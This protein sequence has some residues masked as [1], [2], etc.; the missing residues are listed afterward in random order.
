M[1]WTSP[2]SQ[3]S[4]DCFPLL[5]LPLVAFQ[6]LAG[7]S[8]PFSECEFH[9]ER[10]VSAVEIPLQVHE[11]EQSSLI[12][13]TLMPKARAEEVRRSREHPSPKAA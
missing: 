13:F 8:S 10:H 12:S 11:T 4:S 2:L 9:E 1:S 5:L 6:L 3:S 7:Q